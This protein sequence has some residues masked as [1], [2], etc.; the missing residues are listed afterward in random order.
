MKKKTTINARNKYIYYS[1]VKQETMTK[2][3]WH[4]EKTEKK[5]EKDWNSTMKITKNVVNSESRLIRVLKREY[6]RY[7][8]YWNMPEKEIKR[9][10][11]TVRKKSFWKRKTNNERTHKRILKRIQEKLIQN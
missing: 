3:Q 2:K 4:H 8:Y 6:A 10:W 7:W 9:I 5:S 11:K 1:D